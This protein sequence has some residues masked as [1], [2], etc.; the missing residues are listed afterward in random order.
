MISGPIFMMDQPANTTLKLL[1]KVPPRIIGMQT[2]QDHR[3]S[4]P[5]DRLDAIWKE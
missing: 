1:E 3:R 5:Y 2:S 4:P